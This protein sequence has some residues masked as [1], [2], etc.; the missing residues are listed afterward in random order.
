MHCNKCNK[1]KIKL[2]NMRIY[3]IP[4]HLVILCLGEFPYKY[5]QILVSFKLYIKVHFRTLPN[6]IYC[7][8]YALLIYIYI[9]YLY[10]FISGGRKKQKYKF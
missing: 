4:Q 10:R 5:M 1:V 7:K 6:E 2:Q 9:L 8:R 3:K